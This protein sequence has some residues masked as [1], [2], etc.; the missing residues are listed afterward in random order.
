VG[1]TFVGSV[2]AVQASTVGSMVEGR[3]EELA[4]DEGDRVE[5]GGVIARLRDV[6]LK[7]QLAI[8]RRQLQLS[9]QALAELQTV[10]PEEIEQAR[11]RMMSAEALSQYADARLRRAKLLFQ[12]NSISKEEL[13]ERESAAAAAVEK[14]LENKSAWRAA[15]GSQEEKLAK[16]QLGVLVRRDEVDRLEDD[17]AQHTIVA[18]FSGYV[19]TKHTE[20]GQWVAKGDPVVEMVNLDQVDVEVPVPERFYPRVEPGMTARVELAAIPGRSWEEELS[21]RSRV[22]QADVR[23]RTFRLKVRLENEMGTGER[24]LLSAG[25]FAQVTLPVG[26]QEQSL[27]V[28]KDAVVPGGEVPVLY[29]VDM[30]PAGAGQSGKPGG[31]GEGEG[32]GGPPAAP[33][34]QQPPD[35]TA[36][37]VPVELG[38]ALGRMIEVRVRDPRLLSE[39]DLIVVEGNERLFPRCP[40]AIVNRDQVGK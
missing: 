1:Q 29:A 37:W 40:V 17:L 13:Q 15:T 7:L 14:A 25:M 26:R 24:P 33:P 32:G 30:L 9:E 31:K 20:V 28:P 35:G 12:R 2:E 34:P 23:S 18:P 21:P 19:V 8:A 3:V 10:L 38:A 22:P 27:L 4:V 16:A 39:G 6:Q 5:K 11:A 36:R